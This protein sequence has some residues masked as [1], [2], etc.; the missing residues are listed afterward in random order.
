VIDVLR[1]VARLRALPLF[2]RE[3]SAIEQPPDFF[4]RR[5]LRDLRG[6]TQRMMHFDGQLARRLAEKRTRGLKAWEYGNLF[7][8]LAA[9]PQS[10]EW[11][12]LDVGPGNSALPFYMAGHVGAVTTLDYDRALEPVSR[13]NRTRYLER[14][15][16]YVC[17]SMLDLPFAT[18]SFDLVTCIS[19]IEHLD[20]LGDARQVPY[21]DF[22]A[23]TRAGLAEMSRV[24]RPGGYLYLTTDACVN[25]L[26]TIDRW[27][28]KRPPGDTRWSIY[29]LEDIAETFLG[30]L[31]HNELAVVSAGD[32]DAHK[33]LADAAR[34]TYRGR[35]CTTIIVFAR[36]RG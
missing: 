7:S 32:F 15:L 3:A 13:E 16:S 36:K 14:D 31:E 4:D 34:S 29:R 23:R 8:L 22:L 11:S 5:Q 10:R 25:D 35:Y 27:S 26:Q 21:A 17:G 28:A 2:W 24:I 12:V 18:G 1:D 30:E 6:W 33:L 9:R 19:T 20:D